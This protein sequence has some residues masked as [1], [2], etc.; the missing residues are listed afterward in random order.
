ML[1]VLPLA[2]PDSAR[3]WTSTLSGMPNFAPLWNLLKI[4]VSIAAVVCGTWIFIARSLAGEYWFGAPLFAFAIMLFVAATPW[5]FAENYKFTRAFGLAGICFGVLF[6][7]VAAD[8]VVRPYI[9]KDCADW[10]PYSRGWRACNFLNWIHDVGGNNAIV[11]ALIVSAILA[12]GCSLLLL[13]R[14]G[15]RDQN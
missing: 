3:G 6:G 4:C 8:H 10:F 7:I 5:V 14:V 12:F 11:G 9:P 1:D 2:S 13:R 15:L